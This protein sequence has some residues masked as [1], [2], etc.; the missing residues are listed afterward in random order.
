[1]CG[2]FCFLNEGSK[3]FIPMMITKNTLL[4]LFGEGK[5]FLSFSPFVDVPFRSRL[6]VKVTA[7]VLNLGFSFAS[8]VR[9][10]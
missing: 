3:A 4:I 9:P 6:V 8:I 5:G 1:M 2:M 10:C 7:H